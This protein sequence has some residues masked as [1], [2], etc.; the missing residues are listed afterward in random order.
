MPKT[1]KANPLPK[2]RQIVGFSLDPQIARDV[3][4]FAAK[5]GLSLKQLFEDMWRS[6]K[7]EREKAKS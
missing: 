2:S 5:E 1:A 7:G 6:Y 3:K 4:A